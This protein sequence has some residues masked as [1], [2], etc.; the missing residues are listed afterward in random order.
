MWSCWKTRSKS[1]QHFIL[2]GILCCCLITGKRLFSTVPSWW[3]LHVISLVPSVNLVETNFDSELTDHCDPIISKNIQFTTRGCDPNAN[4]NVHPRHISLNEACR[5]RK[6]NRISEKHTN[7]RLDR[8]QSGVA[9]NLQILGVW[10]IYLKKE[11]Q[12]V[13]GLY[14][15]FL[16]YGTSRDFSLVRHAKSQEEHKKTMQAANMKLSC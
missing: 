14:H 13:N 8:V 15:K 9:S 11:T 6:Q 3:E 4:K 16:R 5:Q 2:Y 1:Y 12:K 7:E 10:G